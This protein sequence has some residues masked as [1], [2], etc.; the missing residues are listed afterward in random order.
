MEVIPALGRT[1]K[2]GQLYDANRGIFNSQKIF[3]VADIAQSCPT[4]VNTTASGAFSTKSNIIRNTMDKLAFLN[5]EA[6]LKL[7]V[8]N[9]VD[10]EGSGKYLKDTKSSSRSSM[11]TL[12][13]EVTTTEESF[14]ISDTLLKEYFSP[15]CDETTPDATHYVSK[16]VW[17][18]RAFLSVTDPNS[19]N[20]DKSEIEDHLKA[21]IK[22]ISLQIDGGGKEADRITT[23]TSTATRPSMYEYSIHS[24]SIEDIA[25]LTGEDAITLWRSIPAKLREQNG[26]KGVPLSFHLSPISEFYKA[27]LSFKM[28]KKIEI[29]T[30][31]FVEEFISSLEFYEQRITDVKTDSV[32]LHKHV[33]KKMRA[34]LRNLERYFSQHFHTFRSEIYE[35]LQDVR[36][37]KEEIGDL[38]ERIGDFIAQLCDSLNKL[39]MLEE[40]FSEKLVLIKYLKSKGY[41]IFGEGDRLLLNDAKST[42]TDSHLVFLTFQFCANDSFRYSLEENI[43]L[44]DSAR[45]DPDI[46][47][48]PILYAVDLD[49]L[50][51]GYPPSLPPPPVLVHVIY[52][53]VYTTHDMLADWKKESA[54]SMVRMMV[55]TSSSCD[56]PSW[57]GIETDFGALTQILKDNKFARYSGTYP[58]K[59]YKF[60][61]SC[62]NERCQK[63]GCQSWCCQECKKAVDLAV[64]SDPYPDTLIC[65]QCKI[66]ALPEKVD[67]RC[68]SVATHGL[69]FLEYGDRNSLTQQIEFVKENCLNIVILGETGVGKSTFINAFANYLQSHSLQDMLNN[70]NKV[71]A[72]MATE[73]QITDPSTR[74]LK[75]CKFGKKS[76]EEDRAVQKVGASFTQTCKTY[77]FSVGS[78][79]IRIVDTPGLADG[80]GVEQ[81]EMNINSIMSY[82]QHFDKVHAFLFLFRAD[83]TRI[84]T[85]FVY[86]F[87]AFLNKLHKDAV[88]NIIF[89]NSYAKPCFYNPAGTASILDQILE[90]IRREG[91]IELYRRHD[92]TTESNDFYIDSEAFRLLVAH[93]N[94][95]QFSAQVVQEFSASWDHSSLTCK[96]L[97]AYARTLQPHNVSSTSSIHVVQIMYQAL[98][99]PMAEIQKTISSNMERVKSENEKLKNTKLSIEQL[100]KDVYMKWRFWETIQLP[101]PRTVCTH[102]NCTTVQA[103]EAGESFNVYT[104]CHEE[105][106]LEPNY[107]SRGHPALME[108]VV[109]NPNHVASSRCNNCSHTYD[110]HMYI[111]VKYKQVEGTRV[112]PKI[113]RLIEEHQGAESIQ[114]NWVLENNKTIE[115]LQQSKTKI[116]ETSVQ[117]VCYLAQNSIVPVNDSLIKYLDAEIQLHENDPN[118]APLL[119]TLRDW[120]FSH[121]ERFANFVNQ[122][123]KHGVATEQITTEEIHQHLKELFDLPEYGEK[124]RDL[125]KKIT[126]K[127]SRSYQ[128]VCCSVPP[129]ATTVPPSQGI[130]SLFPRRVVAGVQSAISYVTSYVNGP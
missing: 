86:C 34:G 14:D 80:R 1:A 30:L 26:G 67:F 115:M 7:T 25:P 39:Q 20:D 46:F 17:G 47:K 100:E 103:T 71:I 16:I 60:L 3:K 49:V 15:N 27:K 77:S 99:E 74:Q 58:G 29:S 76:V 5:V 124:L 10:V 119:K 6:A 66:I 108:C 22:Q 68:S 63:L 33:T 129:A 61:V 8:L 37:E 102:K 70:P 45:T 32:K 83:T 118:S 73:F 75:S 56:A 28:E 93:L 48:S 84:Q 23:A 123:R 40:E 126:E 2:L 62:P 82:L 72:L 127:D 31:T 36:L 112:N 64:R 24:D 97:F 85:S 13:A 81:D 111:N 107:Q 87:K 11:I 4:A 113:K 88:Q 9:V 69:K 109:F 101:H 53:S 114:N 125:Y 38:V 95:I 54:V 57:V 21:T 98:V 52:D 19:E 90:D 110:H 35:T 128:E 105:C 116:E 55:K 51:F 44:T 12:S 78:I 96:K 121:Q 79:T 122:Q 89:V 94:G 91:R 65:S 117:T 59:K 92:D 120:K 104:V 106:N 50:D 41:I 130:T 42:S 18:G 43:A